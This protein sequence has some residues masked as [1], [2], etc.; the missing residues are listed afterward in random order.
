MRRTWSRGV[1]AGAF[2]LNRVDLPEHPNRGP[3]YF[4]WQR[5]LHDILLDQ[6]Y[7]PHIAQ[8]SRMHRDSGK[9]RQSEMGH[10]S[11]AEA[12]ADNA[13]RPPTQLI[14]TV[15]PDTIFYTLPED[16]QGGVHGLHLSTQSYYQL[17]APRQYFVY[18]QS[19]ARGAWRDC[20][21]TMKHLMA[22]VC[23]EIIF[24]TFPEHNKGGVGGLHVSTD[25]C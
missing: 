12:V 14:T 25:N 7:Y 21:S 4:V 9:R 10:G 15:C 16:S 13:A 11:L 22:A 17:S 6:P 18:F 1:L 2:D 23:P 20:T 8:P 3:K 24:C 5:H 19:A